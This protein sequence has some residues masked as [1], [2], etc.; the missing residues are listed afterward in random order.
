MGKKN[1]TSYRMKK[2]HDARKTVIW[3]INYYIFLSINN[4][5]RNAYQYCNSCLF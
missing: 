3:T 1:K 2:Y 5:K 4:L